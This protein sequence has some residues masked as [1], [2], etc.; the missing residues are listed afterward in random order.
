[1]YKKLLLLFF[2]LVG[3]VKKERINFEQID[4][5]DCVKKVTTETAENQKMIWLSHTIYFKNGYKLD[6]NKDIYIQI[7]YADEINIVIKDLLPKIMDNNSFLKLHDFGLEYNDA[8]Y[9]YLLGL[10]DVLV[11]LWVDGEILDSKLIELKHE[12]E[13]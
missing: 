5:F 3:C 12:N 1:M 2:L 13:Y 9:E 10:D 8:D 6:S 11:Q 4:E 7:I